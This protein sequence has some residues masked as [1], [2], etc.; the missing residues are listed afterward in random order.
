MAKSSSVV[1]QNL[2]FNFTVTKVTLNQTSA[3]I[4]KGSTLQMEA[5]LTPP[6][7][8]TRYTWESK[9]TKV[10]TVSSTGLVTAKGIG[11]TTITVTAGN[12]KATCT[13]TVVPMEATS[14]AISPASIPEM[15]VG[16]SATLTRPC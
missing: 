16:D 3:T 13:V 11:T 8:N 4:V 15:V 7:A 2:V 10:A 14:L 6:E 5:T 9:D 1:T 12:E